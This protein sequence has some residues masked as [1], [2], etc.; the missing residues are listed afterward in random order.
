MTNPVEVINIAA[1]RDQQ[2]LAEQLKEGR[3]LAL[4]NE[5][6]RRARR[7]R[8]AKKAAARDVVAK[9]KAKVQRGLADLADSTEDST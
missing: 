5:G 2:V 4:R 3:L 9:K 6:L 7:A 8:K 1:S